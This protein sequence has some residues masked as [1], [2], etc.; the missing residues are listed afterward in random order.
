MALYLAFKTYLPNYAPTNRFMAF[1]KGISELG[2][3]ATVCFFTP[4]SQKSTVQENYKNISFVYYW[5]KKSFPFMRKIN[6]LFS[7]LHFVFQ[8]KKDDVVYVYG[9]LG[10]LRIMAFVKRAKCYYEID[11]CPEISLPKER[12]F[13]LTPSKLA[14][15]LQK[16][17]GVIVISNALRSYFINHGLS[18]EN[19]H[20]VNMVVDPSRFE[21]L[22]KDLQ[23]EKYVAYCGKTSLFKDGCDIL[24][25][26]FSIFKEKHTDFMLYMIGPIPRQDDKEAL[27]HLVDELD[28]KDKVKFL[29]AVSYLEVPQILKNA[30]ML[31]LSRPDNIQAKYGFPTKLGE[32][33]L[34]GNPVIVTDVGEISLFCKDGVDILLAKP[35][36]PLDFSEKMSWCLN[37]PIKAKMI[38]ENGKMKALESFNAITETNKLISFIMQ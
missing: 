32:Y 10:L 35:D 3:H 21:S 4:D 15:Y 17:S 9:F 16:I 2:E 20:V 8:L 1:V 29:G 19:V 30:Q 11:E 33:L 23:V 31:L 14:F 12:Y 13:K 18:E 7:V 36:D 28:L 6:N 38:G 27:Y 26:A 24:L 25:R 5:K 37:N 34:T 22:N